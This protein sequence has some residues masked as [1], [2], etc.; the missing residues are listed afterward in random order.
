LEPFENIPSKLLKVPWDF[1]PPNIMAVYDNFR[2]FIFYGN[3][4]RN[5]RSV[6]KFGKFSRKFPE[7]SKEISGEFQRGFRDICGKFQRDL[8]KVRRKFPVGF[9]EYSKVSNTTMWKVIVKVGQLGHFDVKFV[10]FSKI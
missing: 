5:F 2:K 8:R 6:R 1:R 3:T 10:R 9:K 7:S 4:S